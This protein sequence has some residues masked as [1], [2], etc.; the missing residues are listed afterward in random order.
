MAQMTIGLDLGSQA[1]KLV[2]LRSTFRTVEVVGCASVAV[3]IDERP[4]IERA[5]EALAGLQVS[6]SDQLCTALPG[7]EVSIRSLAM[8]FTVAKRI[9]QTIG[10]E[11]EGVIPFSIEDVVFD[12][13]PVDKGPSG[14]RLLVA[15]CQRDRLSGWLEVLRGAGLDPKLLGA[16]CLAYSSLAS[17]LPVPAE[18]ESAAV[19]DIGHRLTSICILGHEGLEFARTLSGGGHDVT[20]QLAETYKMDADQAELGKHRDA[21]VETGAW[22]ADSPEA[23]MVS[24]TVRRPVDTLVREIRQTFTAHRSL[25]PRSV[26]RIWLCG[27][28]SEIRNLDRYLA[29]ALEV[30][31]E[32]L[33]AEQLA[34]PGIE[35]LTCAAESP[36]GWI[37]ALSLALHAHEGGRRNWLNL[38]K[39]DYGFKG[40]FSHMRGMVVHVAVALIILLFLAVGH[41]LVSYFSLRSAR[42]VLDGRIQEVT[43]TVLGKPYD[44]L[45]VALSL[46]KE[47]VSPENGESLPKSTAVDSLREIH[48]RMPEDLKLRLKLVDITPKKIRIEG[49]TDNFESISL[50]KAALEK[51]ECFK[52]IQEGKS[53]R[54]KKTNEV[55]FTLDIVNGC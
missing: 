11:L 25:V 53:R 27:G 33:G 8:P 52:E 13:L 31:V 20:Q 32:R 51:H 5:S 48:A 12:Y 24:D 26:T 3:P 49:F 44:N 23:V 42:R 41:G 43:K 19:I 34:L 45:E 29:E 54:D 35:K 9:A 47:K 2:R 6:A 7:D 38:R 18:G 22:D 30:D 1:I 15:L 21:F 40:D 37:K 14:T 55:E 50:I 4:Y 17:I 36:G 39:G 10:F 46:I 16:E 28:G